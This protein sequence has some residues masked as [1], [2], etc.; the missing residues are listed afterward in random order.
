MRWVRRYVEWGV[1]VS[2]SQPAQVIAMDA[3]Y[4]RDRGVQFGEM[5]M[6]REINKAFCG[7][8]MAARSNIIS[9]GEWGCGVFHGNAY[10]KTLLQWI[11]ASLVGSDVTLVKPCEV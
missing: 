1:R 9:S 6:L 4:L 2:D 5:L 7:F 3:L 11:A 8:S 10:L